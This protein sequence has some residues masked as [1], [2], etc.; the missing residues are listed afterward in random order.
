[1]TVINYRPEIGILN[2]DKGYKLQSE[3]KS[4][5]LWIIREDEAAVE[6]SAGQFFNVID[7]LFKDYY[8]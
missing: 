7:Q 4:N 2:G 1:M 3:I 6:V 5:S 8:D